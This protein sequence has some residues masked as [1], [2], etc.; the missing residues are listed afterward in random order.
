MVINILRD[1]T[2]LDDLTGHVVRV[3]EAEAAYDLMDGID[4]R[5]LSD[6]NGY[7]DRQRGADFCRAPVLAR[8]RRSV[9]SG[10]DQ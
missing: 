10:H 7:T 3:Q 2:R 9:R 6:E 4:E 1:G 8:S 5:R